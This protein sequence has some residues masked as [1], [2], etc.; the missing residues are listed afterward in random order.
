[1]PSCLSFSL[2]V[3]VDGLSLSSQG[4]LMIHDKEVTLEYI[5]G[6]DFWY[7]KRVSAKNSVP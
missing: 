4:T 2:R 5:P 7:C 1:M 6:P 3:D